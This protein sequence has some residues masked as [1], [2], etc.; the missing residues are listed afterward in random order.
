MGHP[1]AFVRPSTPHIGEQ[2]TTT[3]IRCQSAWSVFAWESISRKTKS[4]A[5]SVGADHL[6]ELSCLSTRLV[7]IWNRRAIED[8]VHIWLN[9]TSIDPEAL[10]AQNVS[11]VRIASVKKPC[12]M[13]MADELRRADEI[14]VYIDG[15]RYTRR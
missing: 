12:D 2:C 5:S 8:Y 11:V 14:N 7:G 13:P 9:R 15:L 1:A 10:H 4:Y 3:S 6:D